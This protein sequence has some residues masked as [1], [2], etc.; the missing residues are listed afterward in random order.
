LGFGIYL[1][2]VELSVEPFQKAK[3]TPSH[4]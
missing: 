4:E 3:Q 1:V 2:L